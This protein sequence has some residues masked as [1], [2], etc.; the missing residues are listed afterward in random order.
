MW[1]VRPVCQKLHDVLFKVVVNGL[2]LDLFQFQKKRLMGLRV[3]VHV[4]KPEHSHQ[5]FFKLEVKRSKL[6]QR[7]DLIVDIRP[8]FL[9]L[10]C[11]NDG[12]GVV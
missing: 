11:L 12:C 9:L 4:G 6:T 8:G 1:P 10:D 3:A 5:R 2:K 7:F